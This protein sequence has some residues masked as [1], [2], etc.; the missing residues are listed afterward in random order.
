MVA[1]LIRKTHLQEQIRGQVWQTDTSSAVRLKAGGLQFRLCPF[2]RPDP[3]PP[4]A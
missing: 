3:Q 4:F 1:E 2:A